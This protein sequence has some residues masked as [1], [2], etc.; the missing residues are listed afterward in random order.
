MLKKILEPL[1]M[2]YYKNIRSLGSKI[3]FKF[4]HTRVLKN[5]TN[6][7]NDSGFFYFICFGTLLGIVR[8]KKLLVRDNDID[9]SV[10][11][12]NEEER[13][14]F[15]EYLLGKGLKHILVI[16]TKEK[17]TVQDAFEYQ[18]IKIDVSYTTQ[19]TSQD[20]YYAA[21]SFDKSSHTAKILRG[22]FRPVI[23]TKDI[24]YKNIKIRIP[25][26]PEVVLEDI[27]INWRVPD[28]KYK[29]WENP[30]LEKI[31]YIGYYKEID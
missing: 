7:F 13:I 6:I 2:F 31:N 25:Y 20:E 14:Q 8:E 3:I 27:Y 1:Y 18:G 15:K 29:Y 9:I 4:N 23:K 17:G 21:Y 22:R 10:Y 26:E 11:A 24:E 28:K 19:S 12:K 16:Y 5:I 30:L